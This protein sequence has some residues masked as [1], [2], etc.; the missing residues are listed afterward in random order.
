MKNTKKF[1][2]SF[3]RA[4]QN[5]PFSRNP[6]NGGAQT[7]GDAAATVLGFLVLAVWNFF[8]ISI[9]IPLIEWNLSVMRTA[10]LAVVLSLWQSVNY[11]V[12]Y[13]RSKHR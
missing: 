11:G 5:E 3:P 1:S 4:L 9:V 12:L 13:A 2:Q 6:K 10:G 8:A 7:G